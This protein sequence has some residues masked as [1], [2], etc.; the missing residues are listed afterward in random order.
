MGWRITHILQSTFAFHS[1]FYASAGLKSGS[2]SFETLS[3]GQQSHEDLYHL[4]PHL[5]I[6]P[7]GSRFLAAMAETVLKV[8][9]NVVVVAG[10]L[11]TA[12]VAALER[13]AAQIDLVACGHTHVKVEERSIAGLPV[14][15]NVGSDYGVMRGVIFDTQRKA[16]DWVGAE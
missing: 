12:A 4:R 6:P 14:C 10:D 9:P 8:E 1:V 2:T 11:G 16:L 7:V 5:A 3:S 13:H 15:L